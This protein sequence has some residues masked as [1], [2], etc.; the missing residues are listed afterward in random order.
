MQ[1]V[2][3]MTPHIRGGV[4]CVFQKKHEFEKCLDQI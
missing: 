4:N 1:L 2:I 3:H